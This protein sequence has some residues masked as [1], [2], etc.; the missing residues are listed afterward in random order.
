MH[1]AV[2]LGTSVVAIYGP[3]NPKFTGPYG[4]NNTVVQV[5][6]PCGPCLLKVCPGYEHI[7]M[8]NITTEDVYNLSLPYLT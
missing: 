8:K 1:I 4:H 3:T 5:D 6:V 7:C 2:A